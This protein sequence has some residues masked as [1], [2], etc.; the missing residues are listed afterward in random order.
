MALSRRV[1]NYEVNRSKGVA[2]LRKVQPYSRFINGQ[3]EAAFNIQG[4][5]IY[6]DAG[7]RVLEKDVPKWVWDSVSRMNQEG[8]E[9]IGIVSPEPQ[10][11]E[12]APKIASPTVE[13]EPE[14]EEVELAEDIKTPVPRKRATRKRSTRIRKPK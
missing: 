12:N 10:K 3:D 7:T 13:L 6:N 9:K 14:P 8:R 2:T 11:V 4:G 1:H 5:R